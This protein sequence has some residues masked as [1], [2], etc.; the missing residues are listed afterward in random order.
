MFEPNPHYLDC[1]RT[2]RFASRQ[3]E[4]DLPVNNDV[5]YVHSLVLSVRCYGDVGELEEFFNGGEY[6]RNAE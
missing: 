2:I 3:S 6:G 1:C 4:L 5:S